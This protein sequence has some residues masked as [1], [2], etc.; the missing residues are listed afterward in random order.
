M[1]D[2]KSSTD[3]VLHPYDWRGEEWLLLD[4]YHRLITSGD[5]VTTMT[6]DMKHLSNFLMYFRTKVTL[7]YSADNDGIWFAS[8]VEPIMSGAFFGAWIRKDK[9]QSPTALKLLTQVYDEAFKVFV[10][11]I[12]L[13]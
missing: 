1:G 11:L 3:Y 4:W 10:V 6:A 5:M 2:G 9:R 7:A 13:S 8:W 12:G